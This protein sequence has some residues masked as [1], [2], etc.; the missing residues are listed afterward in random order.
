MGVMWHMRH[1]IMQKPLH[2]W[3][4]E[5]AMLRSMLASPGWILFSQSYC[6]SSHAAPLQACFL[7]T[8]NRAC[9]MSA[10]VYLH[11]LLQEQVHM[12]HQRCAIV[13]PDMH[14][15]AV[16]LRACADHSAHPAMQIVLHVFVTLP[17]LCHARRASGVHC[18]QVSALPSTERALAGHGGVDR[19]QMVLDISSCCIF[20]IMHHALNI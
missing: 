20:V 7:R 10:A 4:R 19:P 2:L 12:R 9:T 18:E 5:G 6:A 11:A 1:C 17:H 14:H 3:S 8:L 16:L 13:K 15:E